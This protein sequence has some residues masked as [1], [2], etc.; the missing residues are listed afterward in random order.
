[1]P[2]LRPVRAPV[3]LALLPLFA[4]V[5]CRGAGD[6]RESARGASSDSA[7]VVT[8]A[9]GRA[10]RFERPPTRIVSLIPAVTQMIVELGERDALVGRTDFDTLASVASLP[11]V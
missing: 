9:G 4:L 6:A 7:A 5:A 10:V 3:L 1:M 8:D 11:S 2:P